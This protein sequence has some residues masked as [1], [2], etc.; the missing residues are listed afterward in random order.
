M[1]ALEVLTGVAPAGGEVVLTAPQVTAPAGP[2]GNGSHEDGAVDEAHF[3]GEL[4]FTDDDRELKQGVLDDRSD[5][6]N[7][8][9]EVMGEQPDSVV[10]AKRRQARARVKDTERCQAPAKNAGAR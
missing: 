1:L 2:S 6:W 7:P 3:G 10:L 4:A 8:V 9:V 5:R